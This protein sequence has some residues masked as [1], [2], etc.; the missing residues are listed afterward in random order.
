MTP[1][2]LSAHQM[3]RVLA[4]EIP[5]TLVK[6]IELTINKGEFV[7]IVGHSGC[8]KSSLLYLLGL[9][10]R[11]TSGHIELNGQNTCSLS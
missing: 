1:P 11:P 4:D 9:L 8:G 7:S 3:S 5:V 6:N 2:V 10:D